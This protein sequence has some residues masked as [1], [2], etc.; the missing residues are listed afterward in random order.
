MKKETMLDIIFAN[1]D[2]ASIGVLSEEKFLGKIKY[3]A[4]V[5]GMA[6]EDLVYEAQVAYVQ[7]NRYLHMKLRYVLCDSEGKGWKAM[8]L[9]LVEVLELQQIDWEFNEWRKEVGLI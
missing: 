1:A 2:A 3:L 8:A 5:S 9:A 7:K 4:R 6:K